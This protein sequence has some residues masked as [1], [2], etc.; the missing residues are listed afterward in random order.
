MKKEKQVVNVDVAS[1]FLIHGNCDEIFNVCGNSSNEIKL[2]HYV[3]D[4]N[5]GWKLMDS[6][7]HTTIQL[8]VSDDNQTYSQMN[9]RCLKYNSQKINVVTDTGGPR[10]HANGAL[11]AINNPDSSNQISCQLKEQRWWPI[12]G[13]IF[14]KLMA[15]NE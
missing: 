12:T 14:M 10:S 11:I 1:A 3:F 9:I 5:S 6:L 4:S 13:S 15:K 8:T 2:Y 7:K